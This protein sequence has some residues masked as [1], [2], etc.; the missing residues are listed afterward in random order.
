MN[1]ASHVVNGAR[2]Y[3]D[4]AALRLGDD[5]V[6]YRTLDQRT[7]RMAELLRER[8]VRPGDHVGLMLTDTPE[9]AFAYFGVLRVG[10]VVV[11]MNFLLKSREVAYHLGDSGARL[12]FA[13]HDFA[14]EARTGAQQA[15][16][17]AVIVDAGGFD[18]L[19]ASGPSADDVADRHEDDTAVVLYTSGTTGEPKGAELTHGNLTRNCDIVANDLLQLTPD[20]VIF[21]GLPLFH[22]FGQTCALN[23]AVASGACVTLLPRFDAEKTLA[24]LAGHGVTVFAAVPTIFS[25]LLQQPDPDAYDVS[26]LRLSLSGGAAMPVQVLRDFQDAFHCV[27][28]EGYGLSETSP[29]T[30]FNT[31]QAGPRP[32]SVGT[33]IRGVEMRVVD[34]DGEDVPRGEVGEIAIRGHNVMKGYWQRPEE[35]AAAIRDG[36]FHT[37]DLGRLDQDGF[38]WIVGR[39]KDMI[40]RGGNNV[41]PR[42]IENVLYEHPAVAEAAVIGVPDPDLGEEVGAAV[43][44]RPG[45]RATAEE[46]RA[47]VKSRVAAYKYP[48][49]VWITDALPKGPTG[50]IIKREVVPPPEPGGR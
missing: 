9:F 50:K 43:V 17:E 4:R 15:G 2:A 13:W 33:P 28:L 37:G 8:G 41:Y 18:E 47:Y 6:T 36:W 14:D 23:A 39:S 35:T 42:E 20:D 11:P 48:R 38:F 24:M 19:P 34:D 31:L 25:R 3:P 40:I 29:V 26:R 5:I 10:G 45:A 32:G 30:S 49:K 1:L 22:A 21:G 12:L 27:V 46:L 7:A 44:L 16:A